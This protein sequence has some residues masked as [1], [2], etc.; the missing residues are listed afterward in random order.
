MI[1]R[2]LTG[3]CL[4]I[5]SSGKILAGMTAVVNNIQID[6]LKID[7]LMKMYD[8]I[9][10]I[11]FY[12]LIFGVILFAIGYVPYIIKNKNTYHEKF[13]YL[14]PKRSYKRILSCIYFFSSS[15]RGNDII[16]LLNLAT[17]YKIDSIWLYNAKSVLS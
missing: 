2:L 11:S 1:R 14:F 5:R 6:N 3:V 15:S 9:N 4:G 8:A 10:D 16:Y 7:L 12:L 17:V 13:F